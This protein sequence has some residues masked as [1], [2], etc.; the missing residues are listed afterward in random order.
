MKEIVEQIL[1]D[2]RYLEN[3]ERGVPRAGHPE[4]SVKNHIRELEQNL[5]DLRSRGINEYQYWRLQFLIHVH[6]SFKKEA[7]PDVAILDPRSHATLAREYASQFTSDIDLLNMIQFHDE[8]YALWKQYHAT[9][10][11]DG[12]RFEKLLGAITDWD[13]FL[14]FLII[15]GNTKGKERSKLIWFIR[16]VRK[17]KETFVDETWLI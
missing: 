10:S 4:G 9:G 2:P 7:V 11:Y 5:E 17:H 8:N 6:D 14:M 1:K 16:E 13:L 12:Q 15:D 3:I